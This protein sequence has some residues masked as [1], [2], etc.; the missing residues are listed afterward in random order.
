[1]NLPALDGYVLW[2]LPD[3]SSEMELLQPIE[4]ISRSVNSHPFHPHITIGRVPDLNEMQ[5]AK[6]LPQITNDLK[7]FSITIKSVECRENPYQKLILTL[8]HHP[9]IATITDAIDQVFEGEFGKR[10]DHHISMLYAEIPCAN[11]SAEKDSLRKYLSE[12]FVIN[13]VALVHLRGAPNE[14]KIVKACELNG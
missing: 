4:R 10:N 1:M 3:E 14:W 5:L 2:L 8:G 7:P 6:T 9:Q 13:K 11:V 12:S